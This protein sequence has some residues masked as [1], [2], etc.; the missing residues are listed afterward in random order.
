[1]LAAMPAHDSAPEA[2]EPSVEPLADAASGA[3]A[4]ADADASGEDDLR[5]KFR[6]ALER[7]N[8]VHT[9]GTES[10]A[11]GQAKVRGQHGPAA[12]RREFRRKS[13]G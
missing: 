3:P 4:D 9:D 2:T 8:A 12:H 13:G 5:R 10:G 6:E 11:R 7:K 1:M